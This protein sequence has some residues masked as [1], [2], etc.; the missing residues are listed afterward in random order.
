M[1][2]PDVPGWQFSCDTGMWVGEGGNIA[3]TLVFE[4]DAYISGCVSKQHFLEMH[5]NYKKN[6]T[7]APA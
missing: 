7:L 6:S 3:I 5:D 1:G 2:V 4:F